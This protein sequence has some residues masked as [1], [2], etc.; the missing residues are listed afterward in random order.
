MEGSVHGQSAT[1]ILAN[2]SMEKVLFV[3]ALGSEVE[4]F[5]Q[6]AVAAD[7]T[8]RF[9][10]VPGACGSCSPQPA[11]APFL[12]CLQNPTAVSELHLSLFVLLGEEGGATLA[13]FS[14]TYHSQTSS[15][16]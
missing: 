7:I 14:M 5:E 8:A 9:N 10:C 3:G 11:P 4:L 16:H 6:D 12:R 15:S 1:G 2:T 13:S